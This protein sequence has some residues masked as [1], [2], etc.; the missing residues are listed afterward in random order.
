MAR[1]GGVKTGLWKVDVVWVTQPERGRGCEKESYVRTF[2]EALVVVLEKKGAEREAGMRLWGP[3][4][5]SWGSGTF[6]YEPRGEGQA[7]LGLGE[8]LGGGG[9]RSS[10]ETSEREGSR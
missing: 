4:L 8:P 2:G 1:N 3:D 5:G 10:K 7:G 9:G 6:A